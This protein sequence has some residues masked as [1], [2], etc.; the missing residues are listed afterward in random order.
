MIVWDQVEVIFNGH[1]FFVMAGFVPAV[2]ARDI[3][4]RQNAVL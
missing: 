4:V 2:D 1:P 3:G